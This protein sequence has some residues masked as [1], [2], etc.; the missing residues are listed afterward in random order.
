MLIPYKS[1][2]RITTDLL[3]PFHSYIEVS[4]DLL[5]PFHWCWNYHRPADSI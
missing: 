2:V 3:I 4:T 5:I 1:Y